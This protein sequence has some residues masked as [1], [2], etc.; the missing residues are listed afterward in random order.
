MNKIP[1]DLY[2]QIE[3]LEFKPSNFNEFCEEIQ[4]LFKIDNSDRLTYEY[5]TNDGEFHCLDIYNYPNFYIEDNVE[6]IFAYTS[7][8]EANTYEKQKK[9]ENL[10]DEEI[11]IKVDSDKEN[12]I[13]SDNINN[14]E[15]INN[16]LNSDDKI[17]QQI[18]N[19]QL[20]KIRQSKN[21]NIDQEKEI[22]LQECKE[23]DN[24]KE[25]LKEKNDGIS[26]ELNDIINKNFEKLKNDLIT[27]L[28]QIVM[29]S[30]LKN[31]EIEDDIKTPS[32]VEN[33]NGICCSGCGEC[34]IV[35]IRYKCVYC[36]DFDYCEKCEEEKGYVH[37]HPLYKLR[38]KIN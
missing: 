17:K 21:L 14:N 20:E 19:A 24:N 12:Q 5:L 8:D 28:S 37:S 26:E 11:I 18:I 36:S 6:K 2:N 15:K 27:Q 13:L 1:V 7:P 4:R 10:S 9:K 25:E 23:N 22:I 33:H 31:N 30:T 16:N 32:S 29:E 38:F 35:G 3:E 34:P